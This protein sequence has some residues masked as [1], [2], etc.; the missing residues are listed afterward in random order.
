MGPQAGDDMDP[1][2]EARKEIASIVD[3]YIDKTPK[4]R[5]I[6][7]IPAILL[8]A[9]VFTAYLWADDQISPITAREALTLNVMIDRA[10]VETHRPRDQIWSEIAERTGA[11][12]PLALRKWYYQKALDTVADEIAAARLAATPVQ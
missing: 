8:V 3:D 11:K 9:S 4:I 2:E 7:V 12:D 10:A 6:R 5:R 1:T